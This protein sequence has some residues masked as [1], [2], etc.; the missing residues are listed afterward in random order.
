MADIDQHYTSKIEIYFAAEDKCQFSLKTKLFCQSYS[1]LPC[2]LAAVERNYK[3]KIFPKPI[4]RLA[5]K[6]QTTIIGGN[7]ASKS[8]GQKIGD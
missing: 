7:A 6:I 8:I 5:I 1:S 4:Y 3:M 2:Y